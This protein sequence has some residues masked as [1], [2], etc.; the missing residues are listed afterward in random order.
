MMHKDECSYDEQQIKIQQ[1]EKVYHFPTFVIV[2][3]LN[4]RLFLAAIF[5]Y[6]Y[7][8][9]APIFSSLSVKLAGK[10]HDDI[11]KDSQVFAV[12]MLW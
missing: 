6:A 10:K 3:L 2:L 4:E 8:I 12:V 7:V 1:R 11:D 5:E 9:T